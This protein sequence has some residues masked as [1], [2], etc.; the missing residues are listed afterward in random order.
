VRRIRRTVSGGP[1]PRNR[2]H[3]PND[4]LDSSNPSHSGAAFRPSD[5]ALS[6]ARKLAIDAVTAEV[7]AAFRVAGTRSILIKG[8]TIAGWLYDAPDE[9]SYSDSDIWAEP[10]R[11]ADAEVV[12]TNLGFKRST[13]DTQPYGKPVH[14]FS[15]R[16]QRDGAVVDLH[17]TVSGSEVDS[18]T[19][20]RVLSTET[21][22]ISIQGQELE[23]LSPAAK[24]LLIVFHAA[25]HGRGSRQPLMDLK[26]AIE[27]LPSDTWTE[28]ASLAHRLDSLEVLAAGLS[29]LHQGKD[30]AKRLGLEHRL[31]P[32]LI[33]K[34]RGAPPLAPGFAALAASG[35]L[36]AKARFIGKRVAPDR[37][38]MR[39][40]S[41]IAR[42]GPTG[43]ALAYLWRPFWLLLHAPSGF[44]AWRRARNETR[45]PPTWE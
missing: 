28:A 32:K 30:L 35:S 44:L 40:W 27:R 38:F 22:T 18:Q 5:A 9:R 4:S 23:T 24:V 7:T 16:R 36:R 37:E 1:A 26:R 41:S 43:L 31:T 42:R 20:W 34:A 15:W 8:P 25:H 10:N 39:S 17:H 11:I 13:V 2:R 12:L 6:I 45:N 21:T 19:T 33:L 14:A 29:L 3:D